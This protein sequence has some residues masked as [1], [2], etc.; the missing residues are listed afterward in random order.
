MNLGPGLASANTEQPVISVNT[1]EFSLC[2]CLRFSFKL[3]VFRHPGG[4][5]RTVFQRTHHGQSPASVICQSLFMSL[6]WLATGVRLFPK[7]LLTPEEA[8]L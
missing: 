7:R 5:G 3:P 4:D 8:A 6:E 2:H 1:D